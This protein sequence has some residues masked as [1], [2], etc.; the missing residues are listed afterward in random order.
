MKYAHEGHNVHL[1]VYYIIWCPKRRRKVRVG[2]VRARLEQRSNE[3]VEENG[4][5]IISSAIQP[6]HVHRFIGSKP[7]TVP[8]DSPLL[9]KG[10][11]SHDWREEF[12]HLR[13]VASRWTRAFLLSTAGHVSQEI[14]QRYLER[15]SKT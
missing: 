12:A 14:I 1:V 5:E 4:G 7:Y 8:S 10:R 11:S 9:I 13:K 3:V 15:P 6:E 2:P